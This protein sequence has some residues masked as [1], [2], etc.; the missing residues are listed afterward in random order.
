MKDNERCERYAVR[1]SLTEPRGQKDILD[2]ARCLCGIQDQIP[3]TTFLVGRARSEKANINELQ[4]FL[5]KQRRLVRTWTVRGTIH[6]IATA[7]LPLFQKALW[8]EWQ[9]RWST[10]LDQHTTREQRKIAAMAALEVLKGGPITRTQLLAGVEQQLGIRADWLAYLFSSWGGVLKELAYRGEVIH[11]PYKGSEVC[12][13]RT[14]DWLG[15]SVTKHT[16]QEPDDALSVL[17]VRYLQAYGPATIQDFAYWSGV[18][19]TRARRALQ[20]AADQISSGSK[21]KSGP[22]KLLDVPPALENKDVDEP[23]FVA[24]L[25]KFDSY[26]LAHKDKFYLTK[27]YYKQVFRPGADVAAVVLVQ[28]EIVGTW[29]WEKKGKRRGVIFTLFAPLTRKIQQKIQEEAQRLTLEIQAD[30]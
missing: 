27:D 18:T 11:G 9:A 17:L 20:L 7:D 15:S 2:I 10:F 16:I 1:Q 12:F 30:R 29:H 26:V 19:V 23:A 4:T 28:G 25:P 3:G 21:T 5:Y 13:I 6:V 22:R 8:P 24:F 14:E